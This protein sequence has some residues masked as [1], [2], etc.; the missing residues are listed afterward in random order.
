MEIIKFCE[1]QINLKKLNLEK[2]E[3]FKE[4]INNNNKIKKEYYVIKCKSCLNIL[5]RTLNIEI[6]EID[7]NKKFS[8]VPYPFFVSVKTSKK[9][10]LES[11]NKDG[12]MYIFNKISCLL[13]RT[14]IG[15]YI[16]SSTD[17]LLHKLKNVKIENKACEL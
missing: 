1:N 2:D 10:V 17:S 7:E 11:I 4:K 12:D 15:K 9:K 6:I 16:V 13:C 14:Y 5:S 8:Y 3:E